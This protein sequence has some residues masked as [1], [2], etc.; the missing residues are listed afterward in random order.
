MKASDFGPGGRSHLVLQDTAD[1]RRVVRNISSS[2]EERLFQHPTVKMEWGSDTD[3]AAE[4]RGN[5][6]TPGI[7]FPVLQAIVH[8]CSPSV[9]SVPQCIGDIIDP[10]DVQAFRGHMHM[11][12]ADYETYKAAGL[13]TVTPGTEPPK[14]RTK[15]EQ[16]KGGLVFEARTSIPYYLA[17]FWRSGNFDDVVPAQ[18]LASAPS[19]DTVAVVQLLQGIAD[20]ELLTSLGGPGVPSKDAPAGAVSLL[21]T[22]H[23]KALLHH[24]FVN[25]MYEQ[26]EA[27]GSMICFG[28]K[29]SP[30]FWPTTV[31]P[32][33]ATTKK[34]RS[35]EIST[36]KMRPTAD[37]SWPPPN[38]WL[39]HLVTS[40]N[41]S[42]DLA[43]DFP[44][45]YYIGTHD[46][47]EQIL[48][49]SELGQGVE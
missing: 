36:T 7:V 12:H 37:Y 14:H 1:G 49:L 6:G 34:A 45:V 20:G 21:S 42:V 22:N 28:M 44:Y 39:S 8:L 11:A 41:D 15:K 19:L 17:E 4:R 25:D 47:I 24:R 23:E 13:T 31:T 9:T 30:V 43:T 26:E 2:E 32:T 10:R 29:H 40:P 33:G 5:A 35:G 3:V 46:L 38:Y 16:C 48:Y 27:K 18:H